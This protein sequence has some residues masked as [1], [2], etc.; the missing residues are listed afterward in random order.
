M[1]KKS[2][3]RDLIGAG[4]KAAADASDWL[5]T[6]PRKRR[7]AVVD[8]VSTG[9]DEPRFPE[10]VAEAGNLPRILITD[11]MADGAVRWLT[12]RALV[13]YDPSILHDEA[14]LER[15]VGVA[16]VW[17]ARDFSWISAERLADARRLRVVGVIGNQLGAP[18]EALLTERQ[19]SVLR[20]DV[21]GLQAQAE[22]VLCTAM[23][24]L[25]RAY[26][27]NATMTSGGWPHAALARGSEIAG[28]SL[29]LLGFDPAAQAVA[30]LAKAFGMSILSTD[31]RAA[32]NED[33]SWFEFDVQAMTLEEL[34]ASS[35]V[36][37]VHLPPSDTT[38]GMLDGAKLG[39]MKRG[40]VLINTTHGRL[41]NEKAL[42]YALTGG[43][44]AGA[45]LDV[46]A[47]QPL[48]PESPLAKVP[49]LILTPG[50]AALSV[51]STERGYMELA[52]KIAQ[53]LDLW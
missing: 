11:V 32:S 30:R 39:L 8:S 7:D 43:H 3:F 47:S 25:R 12:E 52:Q 38:A 49:N 45:A 37:S 36:L 5:H 50:I 24:L 16:D 41:I 22:Y 19:V 26:A 27:A 15:Y 2:R 48:P 18:Q 9:Q 35:D 23:M 34:L 21:A 44:L 51:E 1:I 4:S 31:E 13:H 17:I 33:M 53:K 6:Q 28:K 14:A 20:A 10:T 40:A 42:A 46:F 29:G